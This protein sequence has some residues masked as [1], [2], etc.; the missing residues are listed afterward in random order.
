MKL[1]LPSGALAYAK[2]WL[3]GLRLEIFDHSFA[4]VGIRV[5]VE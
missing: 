5:D 2:Q 4:Y 1:V 3:I